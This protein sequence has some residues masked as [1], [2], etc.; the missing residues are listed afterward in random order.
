MARGRQTA[1]QSKPSNPEQ[2]PSLVLVIAIIGAVAVIVG[3]IITYFGNVTAASIPVEAA[4]TAEARHT[5]VAITAQA[6]LPDSTITPVPTITPAIV[7][8]S[9]PSPTLAVDSQLVQLIDNYYTCINI[10]NT[11][12]DSDYEECW[13]LLSDRPGEFQSNLNKNNFKAYWKKYKVTYALYY[14]SKN[15]QSY[16]DARYYLYER[17]DLSIPIGNGSPFYLEYLFAFDEN[18][19]R[20]KGADDSISEIG[21]YCESQPRIEKLSLKP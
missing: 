15:L 1:Q 19:W 14:C 17:S 6:Y 11:G 5:A 16:V 21:S 3:S 9:T 4:Q 18:G 8:T 2:K 10:A 12:S 7:A 20:I 13:N